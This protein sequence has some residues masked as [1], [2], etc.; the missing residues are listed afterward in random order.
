MENKR[1]NYR[2][3][4]PT[5]K[6]R[7][8]IESIRKQY[9]PKDQTESKLEKLRRLDAKVQRTAV[10]WSLVLG[11]V[12]VLCFGLG[13]AMVLEWGAIVW[14]VVV[15]AIGCVP[16]GFAYPTYSVVLKRNKNKYCAEILKLSEELLGENK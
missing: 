6:E 13:L 12:G 1:F 10:V 16:M 15:A 5:D 9:L 8:E 7:K 14:G 11:V 2:Y 4:A 3:V